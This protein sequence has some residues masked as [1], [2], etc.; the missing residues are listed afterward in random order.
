MTNQEKVI[1]KIRERCPEL[2]KLSFGCLVDWGKW[3]AGVKGRT[4]QVRPYQWFDAGDNEELMSPEQFKKYKL[5]DVKIIGHEPQLN[6]LLLAIRKSIGTENYF[7]IDV[8][9]SGL[10][11]TIT[12]LV[13]DF[14]YN[15]TKSVRQNLEENEGLCDFLVDVLNIK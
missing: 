2:K 5:D 14:T 10:E 1:E 6:H 9:T 13:S 12:G 11:F 8:Y 3:G 4:T 7:Q 15:L